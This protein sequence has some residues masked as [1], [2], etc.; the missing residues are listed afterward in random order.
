[1]KKYNLLPNDAQILATC[2]IYGIAILAS[3]DSDF[4]TACQ[5]EGITLMSE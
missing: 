3:Y 4:A 2:K 1:M 5:E